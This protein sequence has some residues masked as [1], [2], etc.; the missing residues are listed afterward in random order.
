MS[1]NKSCKKGKRTGK[2]EKKTPVGEDIEE[3]DRTPSGTVLS[4]SVKDIRHFFSPQRMNTL[5]V[6]SQ[7]AIQSHSFEI[8]QQQKQSTGTLAVKALE[9]SSA[10]LIFR[11]N[12]QLDHVNANITDASSDDECNFHTPKLSTS[13]GASSEDL[14]KETEFLHQLA[15]MLPTLSD[16]QVSEMMSTQRVKK[17][18]PQ[19]NNDEFNETI[20]TE[21]PTLNNMVSEIETNDTANPEAVGVITVMR[22]LDNFKK[23][24]AE[25]RAL[26]NRKL[27]EDIKQDIKQD[28][29]QAKEDRKLE[30]EEA[31]KTSEYIQKIEA[32]LCFWKLKSE[33]LTEICNRMSI[34]MSDL[35]TRMEN[36]EMSTSKRMA[37]ITGLSMDYTVK[38]DEN[39][40]FLNSFLEG[41]VVAVRVDDYFL[42][43]STAPKPIVIV[44]QTIEDKKAVLAHK[45]QL[46]R[47]PDPVT[48]G[49]IFINDYLP[50]VAQEKK[51]RDQQIVNIMQDKGQSEKVSYIKGNIAIDG[52]VYKKKIAPPTPKDLVNLGPDALDSILKKKITKR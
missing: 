51:R 44:L 39:I 21:Q 29:N 34:E 30:V 25:E 42:L 1:G 36:L 26:E 14:D 8:A 10:G 35:T 24:M 15:K 16:K 3:R 5:Q 13:P 47:V 37:I 43:G 52:K 49:K 48:N 50:H 23:Q 28:I 6:C 19:T 9:H 46:N 17:S 33:T 12:K 27:R 31:I 41:N 40:S 7:P 20:Q 4:G 11:A 2:A 45:K 32:D 22:L 38:K 18:Q